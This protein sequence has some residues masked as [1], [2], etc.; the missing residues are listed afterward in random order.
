MTLSTVEVGIGAVSAQWFQKA[1]AGEVS[2]GAYISASF[3]LSP[4]EA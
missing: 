4:A 1:D 2:S 3:F